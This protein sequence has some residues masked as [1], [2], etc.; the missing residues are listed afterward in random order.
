MDWRIIATALS[1]TTFSCSSDDSSKS[2]YSFGA[3]EIAPIV[4]SVTPEG[5]TSSS[6]ALTQQEYL[7]LLDTA[8]TEESFKTFVTSYVF[9]KDTTGKVAAPVFYRYWIDV[10]DRTMKEVGGRLAESEDKEGACWKKDPVSLTHSFT[11]GSEDVEVIGKYNCWELQSTPNDAKG[12]FQ[13]MAFGKDDD[14]AY[15]MTVTSDSEEFSSFE[16]ERVIFAKA[17]LDSTEADVWF[18]GRSLQGMTNNQQ[19]RGVANRIIVNKETNAFSYGLSD[20]GIGSTNCAIYAR[21]NGTI[22][23]FQARTP[24]TGSSDTCKDVTGMEWGTGACYNAATLATATGCESLAT[25]PDDYGVS[26][27][28][29]ETDV[30]AVKE[31]SEKITDFDFEGAGVAKFE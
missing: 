16:G 26:A 10:L 8:D 3:P 9:K 30:A 12:G 24:D 6:S 31:G 13:K 4:D 28:F 20:E 5:L 1:L 14:Y 23:N 19:I 11:V 2:G 7:D 29:K 18:I 22:L 17:A 27:P 15:L 25:A 21:S